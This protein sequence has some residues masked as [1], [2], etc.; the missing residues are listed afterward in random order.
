MNTRDH[1]LLKTFIRERAQLIRALSSGVLDK[2]AFLEANEALIQRLNLKPFGQIQSYEQALFN[3]QYYN[4]MAK[5]AQRAVQNRKRVG[6][7]VSKHAVRVHGYYTAKDR[8]T[9]AIISMLVNENIKAY[10]I[11]TRSRRLDQKLIEIV[12]PDREYAVF[13]SLN[14][15]IKKSLIERGCFDETTRN[16][17]I[18]TYVNAFY[19]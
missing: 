7:K 15:G 10:T 5:K 11:K 14:Q 8:A 4:L 17:V 6:G 16:S 13:H 3:Y 18:D 1:E 2:S 19:G 9:A 12:A